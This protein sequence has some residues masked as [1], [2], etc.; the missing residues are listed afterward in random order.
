MR[1]A[2]KPE[3]RLSLKLEEE[4]FVWIDADATLEWISGMSRRGRQFFRV[5]VSDCMRFCPSRINE[6]FRIAECELLEAVMA[7]ILWSK[8]GGVSRH[9]ILRTDNKNIPHW[10]KKSKAKL[11]IPNR[12]TKRLIEYILKEKIDGFPA[13]LRSAHNLTADGITR[14]GEEGILSWLY[15]Q[16][17][18]QAGVPLDWLHVL[19]EQASFPNERPLTTFE[20][21]LPLLNFPQTT[22]DHVCEWR[23]G[24]YDT[25]SLLA[26]WGVPMICY[27]VTHPHPQ[28]LVADQVTEYRFRDIFVLIGQASIQMEINDFKADEMRIAPRYSIL[29]TPVRIQDREEP[30][31]YRGGQKLVGSASLGAV[32]AAQW[33]MYKSGF[34]EEWMASHPPQRD[35]R[36][37]KD[38]YLQAGLPIDED[39]TGFATVQGSPNTI[40]RAVSIEVYESRRVWSRMSHLPHPT[41]SVLRSNEMARPMAAPEMRIPYWGGQIVILGR[42][43]AFGRGDARNRSE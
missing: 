1:R 39:P 23:P 31:E 11:G 27:G 36:V 24:C 22:R 12:I 5:R 10:V 18:Q 42:H 40:G 43:P 25:A 29:A 26:S 19:G 37:L 21:L 35:F 34:S 30:N 17:M 7:I 33:W 4:L 8:V 16:R 41:I 20:A 14:W 9:I 28:A 2:V 32:V 3:E 13:Y 6:P 15:D 38:G